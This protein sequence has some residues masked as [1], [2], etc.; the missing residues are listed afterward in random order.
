MSI[1]LGV[2]AFVALQNAWTQMKPTS[3]RPLRLE[4]QFGSDFNQIST[5]IMSHSDLNKCDF[6]RACTPIPMLVHR[7]AG[8]LVAIAA[9]KSVSAR[10]G[11]ILEGTL[12][13][14]M[15]RGRAGMAPTSG[16]GWVRNAVTQ[17]TWRVW[18]GPLRTRDGTWTGPG[19]DPDEGLDGTRRDS[20]RLL[21][22]SESVAR[23][24]ETSPHTNLI[25]W[26]NL[27]CWRS[28]ATEQSIRR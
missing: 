24:R 15:G 6:I 5:L 23:R 27:L 19:S 13:R 10:P 22:L 17:S 26:G 2:S 3:S 14:R 28:M 11:P 18:T 16:S 7:F 25:L 21:G 20:N 8:N 4:R 9:K 1:F 12:G